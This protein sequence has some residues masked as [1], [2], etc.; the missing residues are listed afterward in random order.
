MKL[1]PK[2]SVKGYDYSPVSVETSK[3]YNAVDIKEGGCHIIQGDVSNITLPVESLD[4]ATAF[5]TIYF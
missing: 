4:L 1:Y 2:A 3:E 5:E